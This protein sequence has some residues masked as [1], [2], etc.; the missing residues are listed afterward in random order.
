MNVWLIDLISAPGINGFLSRMSK[1][2]LDDICRTPKEKGN[3]HVKFFDQDAN[4][5]S[6]VGAYYDLWVYI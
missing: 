6:S 4:D 2:L 3:M 1:E 5:R